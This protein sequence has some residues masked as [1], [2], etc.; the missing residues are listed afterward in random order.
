MLS[1]SHSIRFSILFL[2]EFSHHHHH[3]HHCGI[4]VFRSALYVCLLQY[5][6]QYCA[7][8]HR[9]ILFFFSCQ[10]FYVLRLSFFD[11][12][13][14]MHTH[15]R[16]SSTH[17]DHRVVCLKSFK[18]TYNVYS[19]ITLTM[20]MCVLKRV[21]YITYFIRMRFSSI[22]F[23]SGFPFLFCFLSYT[24]FFVLPSCLIVSHAIYVSKSGIMLLLLYI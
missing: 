23:D 9:S 1:R 17:S 16:C 3:H 22:Q 8:P 24:L 14:C 20:T 15:I 5:F 12:I 19:Y 10:F 13:L 7:T 6:I 4:T 2:F 18:K 21:S 11:Y